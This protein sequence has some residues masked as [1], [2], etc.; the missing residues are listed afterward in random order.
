MGTP[1]KTHSSLNDHQIGV[2]ENGKSQEWPWDVEEQS[3]CKRRS[4]ERASEP[5][6]RVVPR[7]VT[8][9]GSLLGCCDK[10][11]H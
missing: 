3:E 11:M 1:F 4:S 9:D 2:Q 8:Y 10:L 7:A 6:T 5:T